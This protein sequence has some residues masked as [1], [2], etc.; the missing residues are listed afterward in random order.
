MQVVPYDDFLPFA[1]HDIRLEICSLVEKISQKEQKFQFLF[2]TYL[3][4]TISRC[5]LLLTLPL[6]TL[7][8]DIVLYF[9]VFLLGSTSSGTPMVSWFLLSVFHS[10]GTRIRRTHV[11]T[12]SHFRH[13]VCTYSGIQLSC[14]LFLHPS[15]IVGMLDIL[16]S[17]NAWTE[18]WLEWTAVFEPAYWTDWSIPIELFIFS[19]LDFIPT[20]TSN[21][22]AVVWF[23]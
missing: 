14:L 4:S 20:F 3:H 22:I 16:L 5:L 17:L 7:D 18:A 10:Q 2:Y 11:H 12:E 23:G 9:L 8:L 21:V 6:V 13:L 15:R 1:A 19:N